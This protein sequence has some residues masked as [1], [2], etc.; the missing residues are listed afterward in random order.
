M[1]IGCGAFLSIFLM[2]VGGVFYEEMMMHFGAGM[3]RGIIV[4]LSLALV[5]LLVKLITARVPTDQA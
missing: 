3:A 1:I 4:V 5:V 2:V